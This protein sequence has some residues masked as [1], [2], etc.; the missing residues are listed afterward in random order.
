MI[1]PD[2]IVI[3]GILLVVTGGVIYLII[4][5]LVQ[6]GLKNQ[7]VDDLPAAVEPSFSPTGSGE[8]AGDTT[9]ALLLIQAG[10]KILSLNAQ[11]KQLFQLHD[12][13]VPNLERLAL[14]ARPSESFLTLCAQPGQATFVLQ[15]QLIQ[16]ESHHLESPEQRH[17]LVTLRLPDISRDEKDGQLYSSGGYLQTIT[18][19]FQSIT[20]DLDLRATVL[21]IL[22]NLHKMIPFDFNEINLVGPAESA[23]VTYQLVEEQGSKPRLAQTTL[24]TGNLSQLTTTLIKEGKA[25]F[26]PELSRESGRPAAGDQRIES[27]GSYIGIPLQ[28]DLGLIGT[29]ELGSHTPGAYRRSDFELIELISKQAANAIRNAVRFSSEQRRSAEMSS[30]AQFT[31]A[32]SALPDAGELYEHLVNSIAPLVP[33][34]ILGFLL[35]NEAHHTLEGQPPFQGLPSQ[36]MS[37]YTIPLASGSSLQKFLLSQEV[38]ISED[39]SQD[40]RLTDL[41]LKTLITAAG[42]HDTILAPLTTNGRLMGYLQASNHTGGRSTFSPE[43]IHLLTLL[44]SQCAPIIENATLVHQ[45]RLR[46]QRADG[47]RRIASLASSS[48]T[49]D[50]ILK[51][52]LQELIHLTR[53]EVGFIFLV[54]ENKRILSLHQPS[55]YGLSEE[56]LSAIPSTSMDNPMFFYTVTSRMQVVL[57][58]VLSEEDSLLPTY[59]AIA[60]TLRL[61]SAIA[62]P[63][64]VHNRG[65]GELWIGNT[66]QD[67]FD[68]NDL[69]VVVTAGGQLASVVEQAFLVK[70]TDEGLRRRVD[71][72]TALTRISREAAGPLNHDSLARLIHEEALRTSQADCGVV[73]L[74]DITVPP[75]YPVIAREGDPSAQEPSDMELAAIERKALVEVTSF[76]NSSFQRPHTSTQSAVVLPIIYQDIVAGLISLHAY[77]RERFDQA[78]IEITQALAAQVALVMGNAAQYREQIRQSGQLHQQVEVLSKLLETSRSLNADQPL[79]E[80]LRIIAEGIRQATAFDMVLISTYVP[81]VNGLKRAA[82]A[83]LPEAAWE[84]FQTHI[85]PWPGITPLLQ[86]EFKIGQAY[87]IP[88]EHA[89]ATSEDVH[90]MTILPRPAQKDGNA[91]DPDDS[92]LLPL[93]AQDGRPLGLVSLDNPRDGRR[94][95]PPVIEA[96]EIFAGQAGLA[97]ENHQRLANLNLE[98]T[99]SKHLIDQSAQTLQAT[100][101]TLPTL[102]QKD[103]QQTL[104]IQRLSRQIQRMRDGIEIAAVVNRQNDAATVFTAIAREL[105]ARLNLDVAMQAENTPGDP[106]LTSAAGSI[107]PAVN[108]HALFGQR[109]PLLQ[110]LADG[111]I[112]MVDNLEEDIEWGKNSFLAAFGA[113]SFICLPI[114]TNR[115]V[116]AGILVLGKENLPPFTPDDRQIFQQLARQVS[117]VLQNLSL[118]T[119]TRRR[120]QEM[121]LIVEF[122][123]QLGSLDIGHILTALIRSTL[124]AIPSASAGM[125]ALEDLKKGCLAPQVA[126]GY[127][128]NESLLKI[129]YALHASE[130]TL[131]LPALVY[132]QGSARRIDEV[133][134]VHD[135]NLP[136]DDLVHYR[137]ATAGKLPVSSLVVPIQAGAATLGLLVL[138]NFNAPAAFTADNESLA[139]AFTQQAAL[140][141][142]NARLFRASEERTIQLQSLTTVTGTLTSSLER[143]ELIA[144]LL[145]ELRLVI[146]YETATLW[147]RQGNKLEVASAKGFTDDDQR[148]GLTVQIEDSLLFTEMIKTGQSIPVKDMG[149]D[150]RFPAIEAMGNHSWLGIPLIAKGKVIGTI[151]LEKAEVDFYSPEHIQAATTFAGQAAAALENA[152]LFDEAQRRATDLD[153]RSQRLALLNR[154]SS[155]L[156]STLEADRILSL[157]AK[158]IKDALNC[159]LVS[160]VLFTSQGAPYLHLE[161]PAD[162]SALPAA[163]PAAPLFSHL[164][165]TLGIFSTMDV[166]SEPELDGLQAFF[167]PRKTCSL[168]AI[169]LITGKDLRGVLLLQTEQPYHF[170]LPEIELGLTISNQAAIAF[171]NAYLYAETRQLTEAL[172]QR[173]RDRT[174]ELSKAQHHTESILQ[175][176]TELTASLDIDQ[177]LNRTLSVL[178]QAVHAS[179]SVIYTARQGRMEPLCRTRSPS[180][181]TPR[182]RTHFNLV[183]ETDLIHA[184]ASSLLQSLPPAIELNIAQRVSQERRSI[185]I[186]NLA[187]DERWPESMDTPV[188]F[189]SVLAVLLGLG[190]EALGVLI[191]FKPG[192]GGFDPTDI[193][194]TEAAARQI[195][196]SLNNAGLFN[197]IR[198]QAEHLGGMLREQQVEASRSRAILEAVADGVLVTD[199]SNSI[200]LYNSSAE[201]ILSLPSSQILGQSLEQFSGLFGKTGG[202]WFQTIR[203]W[204]SHPRSYHPDDMVTSQIPLEN[205]QIVAIHLAPVFLGTTFLGTVS[206]FRDITQ[207]VVV[208]RLKSE[209][210]AN[211][212]HELRTPMTSIRGYVEVLLTGASG[213]LTEQQQHF[214]KVVENNA[215]RLNVLVNDLLDIS[216]IEAGRIN[217]SYQPIHILNLIHEVLNDTNRRSRQEKKPID[218]SLDA[219]EDLPV[220]EG[221]PERIH[222]I[223]TNLVLNAYNYTPPH[224]KVTVHACQVD[225]AIQVDIEDNGI[226]IPPADQAHIFE[227]FYRG[228]DPLVQATA[229]TGL[230][231]S[232][233]KNLVEMHHGAIWL[234]SSGERGKGSL[235]SFKLPLHS[236][237]E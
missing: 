172:E 151:A 173:V 234:T 232:I 115:R 138:D 25:L 109:N 92:L 85:Q 17:T 141:L 133:D 171:Q 56:A 36:F 83:G 2:A 75:P 41:N 187:H 198:D 162:Q 166:A 146:P 22:T 186:E 90:A 122:S 230:G 99:R 50:E 179:E 143:K 69:Q 136:V 125:V 29:L 229:G 1:Q 88:A 24:A 67:F 164:K 32:Y 174:E 123:R 57:S 142:E 93:Y 194:L 120:L 157:S 203:T 152:R 52:S 30:L 35:Y 219:P 19:I 167:D 154:F 68:N 76:E 15:G 192:S 205:G 212:S 169:P 39:A 65:I 145:D 206:I 224:G 236:V 168:L 81:E 59:S 235:F 64:V 210:V 126:E 237:S 176:I 204:S 94:P 95:T 178:N 86:P 45:S 132:R 77:G 102:L 153:Q 96:V 121:N 130:K 54:D 217:L 60:E 158:E 10:G 33:V 149:E 112:R 44:A 3:S 117:I 49:L 11:A 27:L 131:A 222:Q 80:S 37:L 221:D 140:A 72:L 84:E 38:I 66:A 228:E 87:F 209:F 58:S 61:V 163:L 182:A 104:S 215:K 46:A 211:V 116:I 62:V 200:T 185:S 180:S 231:L 98:I 6:P 43:E 101:S 233:A 105:L 7:P 201:R 213:P 79:E 71:Q 156:S 23:L 189:K 127:P 51:Y 55:A 135:Y 48:A 226:G 134:F 225:E 42:L 161:T 13:D 216:Q 165:E 34:K 111:Q 190:D 207:E 183:N 97:I 181:E 196:V 89:P 47:L 139:T 119:E 53:A 100:Q 137:Q 147:L 18:D 31:Q 227:R 202:E 40:P 91:W 220:M 191:L 9:D 20:S 26:I 170:T 214:L 148:Q 150:S 14:Q 177:V 16:G 218:F 74:F 107:P 103:L 82:Q 118:L 106:Q 63:L 4:R 5:R 208:D 70:Q 124:R 144:S 128:D 12:H 21:A 8:V 195:S 113:K 28:T 78:A 184:A 199:A 197:L 114:E 155:E 193:S 223:L 159:N 110:T 73:V 129:H 175:I 188:P 160:V 108:P